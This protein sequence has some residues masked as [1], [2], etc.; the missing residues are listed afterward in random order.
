[1]Y[2]LVKYVLLNSL[3]QSQLAINYAENCGC[4]LR[5]QAR[6]NDEPAHYCYDCEAEVFNVLFVSEQSNNVGGRD[7]QQTQHVVHCQPCARKRSHMLDNFVILH[8]YTMEE[9]KQVYDN[10]QFLV[11]SV[12]QLAASS[13]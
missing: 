11:P 3:K 4:E 10:F 12:Q 2:E 9:L 7:R 6:Q 1:M 13:N 5:L 8:Q